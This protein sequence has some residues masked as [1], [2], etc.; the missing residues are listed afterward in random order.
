MASDAIRRGHSRAAARMLE[1]A[2]LQKQRATML[3][4]VIGE[5]PDTVQSVAL[6]EDAPTDGEYAPVAP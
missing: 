3:L 4:S 2:A 6:D 5:G 1:R